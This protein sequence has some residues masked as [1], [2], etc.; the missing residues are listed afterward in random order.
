LEDKSYEIEKT[1]EIIEIM[2]EELNNKI[3]DLDLKD[4]E[5]KKIIS[6]KKYDFL[7]ES[8]K[9]FENIIKEIKTSDASKET[10]KSGKDFFDKLGKDDSGSDY[11][12]TPANAPMFK[13][14]SSVKIISK[15]IKGKIIRTS[16][17]QGEYLVQTGALKVI[18]EASDLKLSGEGDE[19][20]DYQNKN[21]NHNIV[22]S[23]KSMTLDLRGYKCEEA[24]PKLD[25]FLEESLLNNFAGV[26]IIHG[27]GTGALRNFIHNYLKNNPL[28]KGFAYEENDKQGKNYGVTVVKMR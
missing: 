1:K 4:K 25:K 24:E 27:M 18:V 8:R 28:A 12:D 17:K 15:D 5:L 13:I 10:I 9:E 20:R 26:R 7:K 14:G 2:K 3:K 23:S 11:D 16:N 19:N 6:D 21:L 22:A